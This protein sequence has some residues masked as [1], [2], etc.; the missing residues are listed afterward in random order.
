MCHGAG[1]IFRSHRFSRAVT[2]RS[3]TNSIPNRSC[4]RLKDGS[5]DGVFRRAD[6]FQCDVCGSEEERI[7]ESTNRPEVAATV[8][9]N[10][11]ALPQAMKETLVEYFG[12]RNLCTRRTARPRPASSSNLRPADQLRKK[13]CVGQPISLGTLVRG[14]LDEDGERMRR[15]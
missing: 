13:A 6:A 11:A 12:A 1:M 3:W 4:A 5:H 9:S 10:A 2:P 14:Q 15:R 8:I 7:L